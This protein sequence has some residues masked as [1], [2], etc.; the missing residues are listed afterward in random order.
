MDGGAVLVL[1][2]RQDPLAHED[3]LLADMASEEAM[4]VRSGHDPLNS[5][6]TIEGQQRLCTWIRKMRKMIWDPNRIKK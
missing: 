3:V 6:G 1:L 4:Q 2:I 5:A